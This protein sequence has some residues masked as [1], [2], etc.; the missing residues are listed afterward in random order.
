MFIYTYIASFCTPLHTCLHTWLRTCPHQMSADVSVHASIL[1]FP[2][3]SAP[4]CMPRGLE[5]P[6]V[7]MA[8]IGMVHMV[9]FHIVM[10][11]T[12][13]LAWS[14]YSDGVHLSASDSK[15]TFKVRTGAELTEL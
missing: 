15:G 9:M 14:L 10:A 3:M 1:I 2:H 7:V 8:Y 13:G 12:Q 5:W 6:Y 11:Y 4:Q